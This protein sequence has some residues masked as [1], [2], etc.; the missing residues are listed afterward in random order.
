MSV[1]DVM[2]WVFGVGFMAL[3]ILLAWMRWTGRL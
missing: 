3:I 1:E 2:D